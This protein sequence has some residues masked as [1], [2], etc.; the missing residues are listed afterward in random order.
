[1]GAVGVWMGTRFVATREAYAHDA[2][3]ERIAEIDEEGTIRTRCFTGKPCRVI[4]NDTTEAWEARELS[5][6]I[7]SFPRQ[8]GVIVKWLGVDPY[9]AGRREG[10]VARGALAAGQ[11]AGVIRDV[12][13]A[14]DV[15]RRLVAETE[16][17]LERL[18]PAPGARPAS[19]S[20]GEAAR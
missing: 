20:A 3:K 19:T 18:A 9:L 6:T 12:P 2:Y 14:G 10:D 4:K 15:L 16:A 17:V 7:E 1:M 11:S 5:D 8:V 13:S